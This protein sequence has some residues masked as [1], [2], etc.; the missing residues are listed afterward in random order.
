M[1]ADATIVSKHTIH[2]AAKSILSCVLSFDHTVCAAC[3]IPPLSS[4]LAALECWEATMD[5]EIHRRRGPKS[6]L[7]YRDHPSSLSCLQEGL[8]AELYWNGSGSGGLSPARLTTAR[9]PPVRGRKW[10]TLYN[11]MATYYH[12]STS[13][14][15]WY[16]IRCQKGANLQNAIRASSIHHVG[17]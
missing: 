12:F 9:S 16:H 6:S 11:H 1:Y 3:R 7:I 13:D 17:H 4:E 8:K 10:A 5:L 2:S 14:F 15:D